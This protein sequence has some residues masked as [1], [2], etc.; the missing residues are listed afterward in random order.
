MLMGRVDE[1]SN[2]KVYGWAFNDENPG[3]H[4][5]IRVMHGPRV[6]ASAVANMMRP[7]LPDAGIGAGD[8][9]FQVVVPPNIESFQ[10]LM[11]IAQS[12]KHGEIAL[13]IASNDDRRLDDLF[14]LFS[15]RYEDALIAMKA[16]L[17]A[18]KED[19]KG[20][21]NAASVPTDLDARLAKLETR[22]EAAELFFIRIDESVRK[23]TE[24]Q[25]QKSRKR[26]LG[27]F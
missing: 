1:L 3:E 11:I 22:M 17:D 10:G 19:R 2:S 6:I 5:V 26:F 18:L 21:R 13:P 15:N 25:K 7:D 12:A 27:I 23:L 24:A 16:E 14:T 20:L 9:A 8:H 4:L